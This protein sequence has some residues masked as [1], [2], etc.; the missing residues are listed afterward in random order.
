MEKYKD[1]SLPI[2]QRVDDLVSKMTLEEK[3]SQLIHS[4][5]AIERLQIPQ[6]NWWNECLHGVAR[7]GR[8]TVFPQA[9]AMAATFDTELVFNIAS[10]ISDEARA[11]YHAAVK[12][13]NRSQYF[14][15]TYWTPNINIFRDPR[16]GRGHETYG[17]DPFLTTKLGVEFVKGLQGDD[18]KYLKLVATPKHFAVHSGPEE[19]RH[20]IN[21]KVDNRLLNETYLPAFKATVQQAKAESIMG[22]YNRLNDEPCCGS[23][24]LLQDILRDKWNFDGYVVSDCGAICDFHQHHKITDNPAES[25]A[26]AVINGC[27]LN[28]GHTYPSLLKAVDDNLITEEQIDIS[29]KRIFKAR[30]KLGMFDDDKD[31]PYSKIPIDVIGCQKHIELAR[32]TARKAIVLLKNENNLLPL[33]KNNISNIAVVGPCAMSQSV[34]LANYHG[35]SPNL[36]TIMG[37]IVAAVNPGVQ[38]SYHKG[39]DLLGNKPVDKASIEFTIGTAEL[40]IAVLGSTPEFEGEEEDATTDCGGDRSDIALPKCQQELLQYLHSMGKPVILVL[41]GGSAIAIEWAKNNI[42]AIVLTWY[43]GEQGGHAVADV[44]FGD[45]NPSGKLPVTFYKSL[46]QLSDFEDYSMEN[47]TYRFMKEEPL[48]SFGYG[49]SYT[50]FEFSNLKLKE[51]KIEQDSN[52]E[53]SVEISNIGNLQGEEVIQ[54]Y[55]KDVEASVP[56]PKIKLVGFKRVS[57]ELGDKKK[58]S[59]EI[60]SEC[61]AVFDNNGKPFIEPGEFQVFVGSSQ[62]DDNA[63]KALSANFQVI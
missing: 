31:V 25:A 50:E 23:K 27:D 6:Y 9:I 3:I 34:L 54:V 12:K 30:F 47:I 63:S 60:D 7:A 32:E 4:A 51:D 15:L 17:E 39:C 26:M 43:S 29:V 53:L 8:A 21:V 41:T 35:F 46:E 57:L 40:V 38:I 49:L 14:G 10:A 13:N 52:V 16:W 56:V 62:P 5:P 24:T 42:D 58:V 19:L 18:P 20:E 28:C 22:A 48:Y 59:F 2:E 36:V 33:D 61:L 44:L 11:K 55:L 37:G 45:C 1:T